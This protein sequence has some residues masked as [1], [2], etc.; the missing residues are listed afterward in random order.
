MLRLAQRGGGVATFEWDFR[1]QTA[2]CSAEFFGIFGL[3]PIDGVM[4]A[5]EWGRF[6]HPDDREPMTT[7]LTRALAGEEPAT[8]DYRIVTADGR[9]RWLSYAGQI[10]KTVDGDRLLGT[11]VDITDRKALE[12]ELRQASQVKDEFLATLSHELRTPL[13]AVL[14]WAHMLRENTIDP[15]MRE[16]AL[17]SLER[18]ARAQAQLVEDLLDVSRIRSGKLPVRSEP[19]DVAEVVRHAVETVQA[20]VAAKGLTLQLNLPD[21]PRL[22]V[23]GDSDRLQQ[24][25]WNLVSNA[26][27]FTPAGGRV[28]VD[29]QRDGSSAL[30]VVRDTGQGIDPAFQP[31]LFERFS[32]MDSS[33]TRMHGGLGLGLS[34]VRHLVEAHGGTVDAE[35]EGQGR[36]TTFRVRL[37]LVSH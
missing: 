12:T 10:T 28:D 2:L 4:T 1:R 9:T 32:Q 13:N 7:H 23:L 19:V 33:K 29:L 25:V 20:G 14:G 24:V 36:G 3:K 27:K 17:E 15:S 11:V 18:N 31:R 5:T 30:I 37:P 26:V 22:L 35:S 21:G 16:R 34:I 6:V 8:A